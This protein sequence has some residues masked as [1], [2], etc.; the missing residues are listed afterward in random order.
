[1]GDFVQAAIGLALLFVAGDLLVRGAVSAGLRYGVPAIL[2]GLTIVAFGTSAPELFVT[3]KASI[4]EAP[5]IAIGNVVGSNIANVL[6]VVGLPAL[7]R[8]LGDHSPETR[9]NYVIM[10]GVTVIAVVLCMVPP[11][12]WWQ[13]ALLLG[14]LVLFLLDTYRCAMAARRAGE[15]CTPGLEEIEDADPTLPMWKMVG[16]ILLGFVGLPLGA[17]LAVSAG[18][19]IAVSYGVSDEAIGLTLIALGTSLP[20]LAT[21]LMAAVRGRADIAIGNV[22][23]SNVFNLLCILGVAS[24]LDE[25][26]VPE[27][28]LSMNLWVMLLS[29]LAL[30]PFIW[31]RADVGRLAGG[32][33]VAAYVAYTVLV[34]QPQ[35]KPA[36]GPQATTTPGTPKTVLASPAR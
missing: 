30:A 29:A 32:V 18:R 2:I 14:G 7:L 34:L 9:R 5:G 1:M 12:T 10:I 16:L 8:P 31:M 22:I 33:F 35:P 24:A 6:L 28:F 15:D 19:N 25:I 21:T 17:D 11:L 20:E 13:S 36:E 27:A 23:G 26:H 4:Q 3:I